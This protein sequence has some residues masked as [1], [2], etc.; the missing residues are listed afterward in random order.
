LKIQDGQSY[1]RLTESEARNLYWAI[2]LYGQ[3]VDA[4]YERLLQAA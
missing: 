3:Q 2:N 4:E 1:Q